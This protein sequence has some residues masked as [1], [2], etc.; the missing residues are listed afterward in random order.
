MV[1]FLN[2]ASMPAMELMMWGRQAEA[3]KVSPHNKPKMGE[4]R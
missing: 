2:P 4:A 3:Q 1:S